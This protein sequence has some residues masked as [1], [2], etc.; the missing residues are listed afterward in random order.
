MK[1]LIALAFVLGSFGVAHAAP[2]KFSKTT[3]KTALA[4]ARGIGASTLDANGAVREVLGTIG[5]KKLNVLSRTT[6]TKGNSVTYTLGNTF[7]L[8][9]TK[10]RVTAV[11]QGKIWRANESSATIINVPDNS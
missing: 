9:I 8:G 4:A 6:S 2:A 7:N 10:V 5:A 1:K 3:Y 11:K